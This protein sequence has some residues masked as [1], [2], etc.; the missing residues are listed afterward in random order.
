MNLWVAFAGL[1]AGVIVWTLLVRRLTSKSW[2]RHPDAIDNMGASVAS[3]PPARIGLWIF[4]AVVTSLFGLFI[5]AYFMRMGHGHGADHSMSDWSSITKPP[6]LWL[7]TVLLIAGSIA[8]QAARR[9]VTWAQP[10]RAKFA[11]TAGG[12][13]TIV[14]LIGQLIAWQQLSS[15]G[16]F[17]TRNPAAAFFYVLTAVHGL[18]LVGGL[19][20]W[21]KT[22]IRQSKADIELIDVRL[23]VEL[24]TVY[25]HYLLLIWLVLFALL[26]ST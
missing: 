5:S 22:L 1:L 23:S 17:V 14:F 7:N 13:L 15:S 16:Y 2:E 24:C 9:A 18:H 6:I 25:W 11:L 20:V 3:M 8:M 21:G 26:L 10:S 4:L 12:L 19:V